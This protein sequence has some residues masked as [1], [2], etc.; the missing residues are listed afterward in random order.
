MSQPVRVLVV[1]GAI[2]LVTGATAA[3]RQTASSALAQQ[4]V[5]TGSPRTA[6]FD[7]AIDQNAQRMIEEGRKIFRYDTFG[8]EAFWGCCEQ[9]PSWE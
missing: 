8:S 4:P 5:A 6:S 7:S 1:A 9:T 2:V 3:L